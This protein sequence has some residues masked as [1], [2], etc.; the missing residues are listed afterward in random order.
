MNFIN[1]TPEEQ[2]RYNYYMDYALHEAKNAYEKDE[3][4]V[5]AVIVYE[6]TI[7]GYGHNQKEMRQNPTA[8]AE[9]IAIENATKNLKKWRLIDCEA[10]ITLEP[11]CMCA[12]AFILARIS[13]IIFGLSD[14][15]SGACGSIYNIPQ[16][17]KLNHTIDVVKG[18]RAEQSLKIL[19]N[20][21][22]QKRN[23]KSKN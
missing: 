20:F 16:E 4:P 15:K 2:D 17:Q 11:C 12:G 14:P 8:H 22:K 1:M 21:F 3:V 13:K 19:Q 6:N 18:V 23:K 9:I 10:Y 5:G 7:V